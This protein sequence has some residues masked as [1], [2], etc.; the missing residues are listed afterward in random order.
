MVGI[1]LK[2]RGI[3]CED[4]IVAS[5]RDEELSRIGGF[6]Q[7]HRGASR[8]HSGEDGGVTWRNRTMHIDH[9]DIPIR[10]RRSTLTLNAITFR[11][12]RIPTTGYGVR[13]LR[14]DQLRRDIQT[15]SIRRNAQARHH[16]ANRNLANCFRIEHS[17]VPIDVS[18]DH[19]DTAAL[20][21]DYAV[22]VGREDIAAVRAGN[23]IEGT[24]GLCLM[25]KSRRGL[26]VDEIAHIEKGN[27]F[28][29]DTDHK[30]ALSSK[31][32]ETVG[33]CRA[34][35]HES[36][37]R[38]SAMGSTKYFDARDSILAP[39]GYRVRPAE[40]RLVNVGDRDEDVASITG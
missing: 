38:E 5:R 13:V 40:V 6:Y 35:P 7:P 31:Q 32:H 37:G 21:I 15:R 24:C 11:E 23:N 28:V 4:G 30:R 17:A 18:R 2:K 1:G 29:T 9:R 27:T 36:D 34:C 16:V 19:S 12:P 8:C 39:T 33:A 10:A 26:A 25:R 20:P 22:F 14:A 3:E